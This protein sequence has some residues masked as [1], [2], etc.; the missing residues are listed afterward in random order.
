MKDPWHNYFFFIRI[1]FFRHVYGIAKFED[2][3]KVLFEHVP[4]GMQLIF[5]DPRVR[6]DD[7]SWG[8][9]T[10]LPISGCTREITLPFPLPSR[11]GRKK[12][13]TL[14]SPFLKGDLSDT[15]AHQ[16]KGGR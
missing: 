2:E 16:G 14:S 8:R 4:R 1:K 5:L 3:G 13:I 12:E 6:E 11:E 9:N 15:Y 7:T 10:N